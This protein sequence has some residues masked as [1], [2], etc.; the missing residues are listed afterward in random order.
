MCNERRPGRTNRAEGRRTATEGKNEES[1][2]EHTRLVSRYIY[3]LCGDAGLT[4]EL[5]QETFYQAVRSAKSY[6]GESRPEVWLCGIAHNVWRKY[7]EKHSR[8]LAGEQP[9]PVEDVIPDGGEL[10]GERLERREEAMELYSAMQRL[11]GEVREVMYLRILG[12]LS[13]A[14]IARVTGRTENWA[15]VTY[16]RGRQRL[17]AAVD[18]TEKNSE[19][20]NDG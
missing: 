13:F 14:E 5:T 20:R 10:P 16:Y 18:E 3:R 19:G 15:R 1:W 4:E 17:R 9:L 7:A 11:S 6:R 12:E 8:R 2:R